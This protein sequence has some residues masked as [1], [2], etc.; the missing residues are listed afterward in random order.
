M[1]PVIAK[2]KGSPCNRCIEHSHAS[3]LLLV[4]M[5]LSSICRCGKGIGTWSEE[6]IGTSNWNDGAGR[7]CC[8]VSETSLQASITAKSAVHALK[9]ALSF[10]ATWHPSAIVVDM[11]RAPARSGKLRRRY[12]GGRDC[13]TG[14]DCSMERVPNRPD[15][16]VL[17]A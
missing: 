12:Y 2:S 7:P 10:I 3:R 16:D 9:R 1:Q 6:G 11:T 4:G 17:E 13:S 8:N 15:D 5:C 14:R